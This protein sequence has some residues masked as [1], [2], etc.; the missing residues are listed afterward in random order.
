MLR[1]L[2]YSRILRIRTRTLRCGSG[3]RNRRGQPGQIAQHP[4][5]ASNI[6]GDI[7]D[8]LIVSHIAV[9]DVQH[10]LIGGGIINRAVLKVDRNILL[11]RTSISIDIDDLTAFRSSIRACRAP[12]GARGLKYYRPPA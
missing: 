2:S 6:T 8:I 5:R 12:Q 11:A 1:S 3:N 9:V 4:K 10:S 7:K